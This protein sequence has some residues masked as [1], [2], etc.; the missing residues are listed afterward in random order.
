LPP[1]TK[2]NIDM[3]SMYL[4][5]THPELPFPHPISSFGEKIPTG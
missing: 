4:S 1:V 2:P 5:L 3:H